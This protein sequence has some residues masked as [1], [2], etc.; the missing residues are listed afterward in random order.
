MDTFRIKI[1]G[2]DDA[3]DSLL[4]SFAS[5]DTEHSDPDAYSPVAFQPLFM[6]PDVKEPEQIMRRIAEAGMYAVQHQVQI[7]K[8]KKDLAGIA[9][10]KALVGECREY[11]FSDM[12]PVPTEDAAV[13]SRA[14]EL[15][16]TIVSV[17]IDEG[18]VK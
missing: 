15:K 12:V 3:S 13:A 6:W 2:Y 5:D 9:K 8:H 1:Q 17:L 7:E 14:L 10:I 11:S 18:L 4:V 16:A